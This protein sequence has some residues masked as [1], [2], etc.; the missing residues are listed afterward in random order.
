MRLCWAS[1]LLFESARRLGLFGMAKLCF[2]CRLF[3]VGDHDGHHP[4]SL[5]Y[6]SPFDRAIC[7]KRAAVLPAMRA[8]LT[9]RPV[10]ASMTFGGLPESDRLPF[11][12]A[13][14][15]R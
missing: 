7:L 2:A 15:R 13:P 3:H 10:E 8:F 9:P 14:I 11:G 12:A 4:Q 1:P 5:P 6:E